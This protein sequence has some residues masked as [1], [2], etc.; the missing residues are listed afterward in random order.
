LIESYGR[1]SEVF[2]DLGKTASARP[3]RLTALRMTEDLAKAN[4][5]NTA[6]LRAI[7]VCYTKAALTSLAGLDVEKA[8]KW[9][10]LGLGKAESLARNNPGNSELQSDLAAGYDTR[11]DICLALRKPDMALEEYEK[12][13]TNHQQLLVVWVTA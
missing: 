5:T 2:G 10:D 3:N 1:M 8:K 11:G 9:V 6:S 12:S 7:S 4:P 13:W